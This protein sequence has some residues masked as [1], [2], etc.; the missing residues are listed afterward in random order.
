MTH[1]TDEHWFRA[2]DRLEAD[3]FVLR[4][5]LPGDGVRLNAAVVASYEHLA[6]W[7]P[8]PRADQTDEEAER[9][10]CRMRARYLQAT[11]FTIGVFSPDES[12]VWG[13]SGFHLR[14]G[15][16]ETR[17]AEI[18]MWIAAGRAGRGLG[19][20]VLCAMIRWA[21]TE[22][23]WLRLDWRCAPENIASMRVAERAGLQHEGTLRSHTLSPNGDR[24]DTACYAI[25]K[26]DWT[27]GA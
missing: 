16:L 5:F 13:G 19:T 20:S 10:V 18:G 7:M 2:P 8:W 22:W 17:N 24:R 15:G 6:P 21:F 12:E 26:R 11:D 9:T 1:P 27:P 23:P 3:G 14:E 25:L 4:S